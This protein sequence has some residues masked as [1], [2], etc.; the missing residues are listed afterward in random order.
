[1][2]IF[3]NPNYNFIKWRW[4]A[5]VLSAAVI[6]SR[7]RSRSSRAAACR[8]ASTSRAA[9]VVV[10]K[11]DKPTTEDAVRKALGPLSAEAD[12]PA[13]SATPADNEILIRL[14]LRAGQPS[15]A[16]ASRRTRKQVESA[17]RAA[18]IGNFT[19]VNREIVGPID[20]RGPAAQGH[21]G[22]ATRARRHPRLHRAPVPAVVRRRRHRRDVARHAGD[23]RV[24]DLV[25][26]RAVAERHRRDPHD[27]RL[28]GERHDRRVRPRPRE[29]AASRASE[30]LDQVVNKA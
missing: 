1:M 29:P 10:L 12:R 16:R 25:R 5:I 23:A 2:R 3:S 24:P 22:D 15:R 17:L 26:L 4:H 9:R 28:F 20:R 21:L 6:G 30:P 18:N 11:F 7:A 19:L 13:R 8:S 14:P 27:H